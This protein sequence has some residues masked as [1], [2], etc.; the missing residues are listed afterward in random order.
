[1]KLIKVSK[2][3]L[4]GGI[5]AIELTFTVPGAVSV[6]EELSKT[7][8]PEELILGAGTVLDAVTA[9]LAILAGAI[10]YHLV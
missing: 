8:K 5:P 7:F 4:A 1:M 6:L 9:R 10:L 3:V 2:A